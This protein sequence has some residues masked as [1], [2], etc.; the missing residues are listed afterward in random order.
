MSGDILCSLV[1]SVLHLPKSVQVRLDCCKIRRE[2][3]DWKAYTLSHPQLIVDDDFCVDDEDDDHDD[4]DDSDEDYN[5]W[6]KR[7]NVKYLQF[8]T[9]TV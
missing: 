2:T 6:N 5:E 8:R 7:W 1:E 4:D 3:R 9:S